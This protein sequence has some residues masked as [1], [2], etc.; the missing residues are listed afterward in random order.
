MSLVITPTN[1][2]STLVIDVRM[3]VASTGTK[4]IAAL[5]QDSNVNS[6]ASAYHTVSNSGA[7]SLGFIHKM[8]AGTTNPT[9]FKVRAGSNSGATLTFNGEGSARFFGGSLV[10]SIL[11]TEI[12]P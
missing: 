11:I 3:F 7:V 12:L 4:N 2:N 6:L 10:S 9:T 8:T 5:F 1:P